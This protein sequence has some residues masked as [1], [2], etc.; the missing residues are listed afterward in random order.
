MSQCPRALLGWLTEHG[1]AVAAPVRTTRIAARRANV[2]TLVTDQR[3]RQWVLRERDIGQARDFS[4]EATALRA[5]SRTGVP[6]ARV[7]GYD[8][9]CGSVPFVVTDYVEGIR[10]CTEDAARQLNPPQRYAVGMQVIATLAGMYAIDPNAMGLP[11]F[12][13]CYLDRHMASMA[14]VWTR[15]G[16]SGL[17]DSAWR[18]VRARLIDRRPTWQRPVTLI[19]GDF[20]LANIIFGQGAI[21]AVVGWE[22]CTAGDPLADLA[23]LLTDWRAPGDPPSYPPSPTRIGGFPTR[24]DLI[25]AYQNATG[26]PLRDL[27]YHRGLAHWRAASLLQGQLA[28]HQITA[29]DERAAALDVEAANDTIALLLMEAAAFLQEPR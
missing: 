14:D 3:G 11:H 6:V 22:L 23:W 28:L 25:T 24:E 4:R 5:L 7:I 9:G 10:L 27:P 26:L 16:S 29:V 19:H 20:R 8:G 21:S 18:A 13:A 12:A 15:S 17:H 1:E 2:T